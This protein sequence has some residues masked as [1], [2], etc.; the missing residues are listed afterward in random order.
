MEQQKYTITTP[1]LT[2]IKNS[3]W[4][5]VYEPA[6]DTF[7]LL[8]TLEQEL[9]Y[10][11]QKKPTI[12]LE[13]GSGS[14]TIISALSKVFN[15]H[16]HCIAI[17]VNSHACK[18]TKNTS[19]QNHC[20]V[21]VIQG[22]LTSCLR[23]QSI[24]MIV[25]N[26]PYVVTPSSEINT[27]DPLTKSW[28]G[29]VNGAEV[30]MKFL[31]MCP[32]ALSQLSFGYL[33]LLKENNPN[34]L[35]SLLKEKKFEC[36]IISSRKIRGEELFVG[37]SM[38]LSKRI[39]KFLAPIRRELLGLHGQH[40]AA[41]ASLDVTSVN[42]VKPVFRYADEFSD[43]FALHDTKG[44]YTYRS[45][46]NSSYKLA[47]EI[48]T[49][50][51]NKQN[52]RV[53]FLCPNDGSYIIAQWAAWMSGQ[54]VVPLSQ[55]HPLGLLEYCISDCDAKLLV[56][57]SELAEKLSPL[58][59]R[60][61][62]KLLVIDD[63][64]VNEAVVRKL[65][66]T[67]DIVI[68]PPQEPNPR[69][70]GGL[71][72]EFYQNSD[73]MIV[74]TSGTTGNPKGVVLTHKNIHYQIQ[75]MV[76]AWGW[77]SK[78]VVLH[79]LPLHH[80]HGIINALVTPLSIG[81][82]ILMLPEFNC[83]E[84]WTHLLLIKKQPGDKITIFMG[85]P[86]MYAKLIDEFDNL[87]QPNR[88]QCEFI[89]TILSQKVRLMI[90]GS[91]PLRPQIIER[92]KEISGH[93]LLER[94]GMT[95]TGMVLG[96]PLIGERKVGFVGQPMPGVSVRITKRDNPEKVLVEGDS[97]RSNIIA[98]DIKEK[99]ISGDLL[100]KGPTVFRTYWNKPNATAKEFTSDEWFKTGDTAE[101]VDGS[102][103]ILG[104]TNVD[105]IKTGGFK[106]SALE[107]ESKLIEHDDIK[108]VAIVGVPDLTWGE[109]VAAVLVLEPEK[110]LTLADLRSWCKQ[111]LA[112]YAI[113]TELKIVE[114]VPRNHMD[115]I[116]KKEILKT[117][118]KVKLPNP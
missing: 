29:G 114:A 21:E 66:K 116:N 7:F 5:Y 70:G 54:I 92:W 56:T 6:E 48:S 83:N 93:T 53:A 39:H 104:R 72:P 97:V 101:Y 1:D 4:D 87:F 12:V 46:F 110:E 71:D 51:N 60:V 90:S 17:D 18:M 89:K 98:H 49:L 44:E 65:T 15:S 38:L 61:K 9:K 55:R 59:E 2:H 84:V 24:D 91:A 3:D 57:T 115:K 40:T 34:L 36:E 30:I 99:S 100:V 26:P 111:K 105:I 109:K 108:D 63:E 14:G 117:I 103:K 67:A 81:A 80:V 77:T 42:Q 20:L 75:S 79:T 10:I 113:P 64:L 43:K 27:A 94:Y 23:Q 35:M 47:K 86:T 107:V 52:E 11:Y 31:E 68:K 58:S 102:Y 85:V 74:Y 45:L 32:G 50:L 112:P 13:V 28:A 62:S 19:S 33:L 118:F 16:S 82:K 25:F 37:F 96:N 88:R 8:D 73:A 95:E 41:K 106:V 78:D 76:T 22:D 69:L